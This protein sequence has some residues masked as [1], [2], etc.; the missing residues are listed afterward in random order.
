MTRTKVSGFA[1]LLALLGKVNTAIDDPYAAW[2]QRRREKRRHKREKKKR[3]A[4]R[5]GGAE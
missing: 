5:E 3:K 2:S 1:G 4:K